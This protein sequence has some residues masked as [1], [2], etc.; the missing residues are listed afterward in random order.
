MDR[1]QFLDALCGLT[2]I[3]SVAM[4]DASEEYPYGSGPAAALD[5]VL[6]LCS[7]WGIRTERRGKKIAWA[8]IG[9]GDELVGILGHLDIV[10]VGEGWTHDP[11]GEICGGRFYARGASDDKG[12]TMAALYAMKELQDAGTPLNRRVRLIFGQSEETGSWDDMAWYREHEQLPVCGFTPDADFPAIYGEKGIL[13][14]RLSL[15]LARTGL[16]WIEG[17]DATNMVPGW[18]R[19]KTAGTPAAEYSASGKSA[20]ASTPEKGENAISGLMEQLAAD[21]LDSPLIEFYRRHIAHDYTGEKMGCCF[22]DEQ[23]GRLT[24]NAG[25]IR[26]VG[27]MAELSIDIRYPVT[28]TGKQVTEVVEAAAA[29][30]GITVTCTENNP[31]IYMDKN[32]AAIQAM[33]E[34]YREVTGDLSEPR[35]IGGGTYAR[36][37]PGIVAFGPGRPGR[38][39]TEHQKDEYILIEDLLQAEEIYRRTIER[40]ANLGQPDAG[41]VEKRR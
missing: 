21:G 4:T 40:L 25:M 30:Y 12:P 33:L 7:E 14:L 41:S 27:D 20:H 1:K 2:A 38:E 35:V 37:M 34:V 28:F 13:G 16:Q 18:C 22:A 11:K 19:A 23:S 15:A 24:L 39:G 32:G 8:E 6:K 31:P 3:D 29:P 5:Y 17:G 10:P 36:S 9:Q 26:T